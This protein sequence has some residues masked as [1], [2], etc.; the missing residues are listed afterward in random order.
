MLYA[1]TLQLGI[2]PPELPAQRRQFYSLYGTKDS[3]HR[4]WE[5]QDLGTPEWKFKVG[6]G[7]IWRVWVQLQK[8][9][10]LSFRLGQTL[11]QKT[12]LTLPELTASSEFILLYFAT[13]PLQK[14]TRIHSVFSILSF[15]VCLFVL[16]AKSVPIPIS[17][18]T[19]T[20]TIDMA[21]STNASE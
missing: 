18:E 13:F 11:T 10:H 16:Y 5:L 15:F 8:I 12:P 19:Y 1:S 2:R 17:S 4:I 3:S 20:R 7:C 14:M 21:A 6:A 9:L